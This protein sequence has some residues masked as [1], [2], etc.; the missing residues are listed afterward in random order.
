MRV[1]IRYRVF[2]SVCCGKIAAL[3]PVLVCVRASAGVVWL[4]WKKK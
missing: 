2:L 4:V 1:Y 3:V